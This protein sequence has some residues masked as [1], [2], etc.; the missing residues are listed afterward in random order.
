VI[1]MSSLE[2]AQ[3]YFDGWNR[4][5]PAAVLA[6]M[7]PDGTYTDPTTGGPLSGDPFA[8]H[9]KGLFSAFPDVS[10]EIASVG[11]AAPDLVAAQWV[12]R[13][14]NTGSMY[15]L[16]PTGRQ[17]TLHGADFIRVTGNAIRSVDGYFDAG[18]VPKQLGLQVVVQPSSIGPFSFGTAV[19]ASAGS[20]VK[21]GAFSITALKTRNAEDQSG[22]QELSRQVAAEMLSMKGFIGW[23]GVTISDRM[24][25]I[26]AWENAGDSRQ[27]VEGGRHAHAMT[28]FFGPEL[29][30]GGYTAVFAADHVNATWVRCASCHAMVDHNARQGSCACGAPLPQP[31]P[32]W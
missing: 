23:V 27:L 11:E 12:M 17:V 24:L 6:T 13:G 22:V 31:M 18:D 7:A 2:V 20:A 28:K 26:T 25:T 8:G 15:G 4:R 1:A 10:F 5:D 21:P 30:G 29:G 32:Y 14:T 19:R 3:R 16:P 9:M